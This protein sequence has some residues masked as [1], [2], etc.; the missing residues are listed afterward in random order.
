MSMSR[1]IA[2]WQLLQ[3]SHLNGGE[4]KL[5]HLFDQFLKFWHKDG[6]EIE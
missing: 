5:Q 2:H 3:Q 4:D 1:V 6:S